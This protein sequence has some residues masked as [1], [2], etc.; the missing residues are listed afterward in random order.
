[1]ANKDMRVPQLACTYMIPVKDASSIQGAQG[2]LAGACRKVDKARG[3]ADL[4][5]TCDVR[6]GRDIR[7]NEQLLGHGPVVLADIALRALG[8]NVHGVA[9]GVAHHVYHRH[10]CPARPKSRVSI[11][12]Y[13]VCAI[14]PLPPWRLNQSLR[15]QVAVLKRVILQPHAA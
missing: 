9:K 4:E 10:L 2:K 1:M 5:G 15:L 11:I 6:S 7:H 13:K 12:E 8:H 14:V 3:R